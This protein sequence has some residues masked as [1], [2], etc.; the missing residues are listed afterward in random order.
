M[1]IDGHGCEPNLVLTKIKVQL[2]LS[3][4]FSEQNPIKIGGF[5]FIYLL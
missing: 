4:Q 5:I 2:E 3:K 1:V